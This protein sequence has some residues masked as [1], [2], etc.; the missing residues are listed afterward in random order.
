MNFQP[1]RDRARRLGLRL[2]PRF[3][4]SLFPSWFSDVMR[5][6]QDRPQI[7]SQDFHGQSVVFLKAVLVMMAILATVWA[8]H[9]NVTSRWIHEVPPSLA[10]SCLMIQF[11]LALVGLVLSGSTKKRDQRRQRRAAHLLPLIRHHMA[12]YALQ[13]QGDAE[14]RR[15]HQRHSREF[16]VCLREFLNNASGQARHHLSQLAGNLGLV[17]DWKHLATRDHTARTEAI[18]ALS[19]LSTDLGVPALEALIEHD[20]TLVRAAALKALVNVAGRENLPADRC[21]MDLP[22]L[23]RATI[24]SSLLVRVLLASDL[25]CHAHSLAQN[26]IPQLLLAE[27]SAG[28]LLAALE[29]IECWRYGLPIESL[30]SLLHHSNPRIRAG[31][32]R[33]APLE[34]LHAGSN[35]AWTSQ[36]QAVRSNTESLVPLVISGLLDSDVTV[37]AAALSAAAGLNVPSTLPLIEHC[38]DTADQHLASLACLALATMGPPGRAILNSKIHGANARLAASAVESL[39]SVQLANA[40]AF[41]A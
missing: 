27:R 6:S 17:E 13:A 12:A 15:L 2:F 8:M 21:K 3:L 7:V 33:L 20:S 30:H 36:R 4:P 24:S 38:A 22:A 35:G 14:L 23:F 34:S 41:Q 39:A 40:S 32:L 26:G 28:P 29:M 10:V 18:E 19:L 16:D 25:R 1:T 5:R 31:A 11:V 37:K 9:R